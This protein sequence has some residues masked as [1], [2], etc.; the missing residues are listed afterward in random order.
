MIEIYDRSRGEYLDANTSTTQ[1][2]PSLVSV[3][4][5][6]SLDD[7]LEEDE[8]PY[9]LHYLQDGKRYMLDYVNSSKESFRKTCEQRQHADNILKEIEKL[10]DTLKEKMCL[11]YRPSLKSI[12]DEPVCQVQNKETLVS[13]TIQMKNTLSLVRPTNAAQLAVMQMLLSS[14]HLVLKT[15]GLRNS[16][17]DDRAGNPSHSENPENPK[18][19]ENPDNMPDD[20]MEEEIFDNLRSIMRPS[21]LLANKMS[22]VI[23]DRD[24]MKIADVAQI[25]LDNR[26]DTDDKID[27]DAILPTQFTLTVNQMINDVNAGF[28]NIDSKVIK[29]GAKPIDIKEPTIED[30]IPYYKD[31]NVATPD[32]IREDEIHKKFPSAVEISPISKNRPLSIRKFNRKVTEPIQPM[33]SIKIPYKK[34]D[35]RLDARKWKRWL[36]K[37][38]QI[39][40]REKAMIMDVNKVNDEGR[41][42]TPVMPF[43]ERNFKERNAISEPCYTPSLL[44]QP[45]A[46]PCSGISE[47]YWNDDGIEVLWPPKITIRPRQCHNHYMRSKYETINLGGNKMWNAALSYCPL[48]QNCYGNKN[49]NN[50][51][52][53]SIG[54]NAFHKGCNHRDMYYCLHLSNISIHNGQMGCCH[55]VNSCPMWNDGCCGRSQSYYWTN[56]NL[57]FTHPWSCW[58][59]SRCNY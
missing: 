1:L 45:N 5:D 28:I 56:G 8:Y 58:H 51:L 40:N 21:I 18:N 31:K 44:H 29:N 24:R 48:L 39:S 38:K 27:K 33:V 35:R 19:P 34:D 22:N 13:S 36:K 17:K 42:Y 41:L 30:D 2:K 11:T 49:N 4:C 52:Y 26:I 57:Y 20:D 47:T 16:W 46:I 55:R 6:V 59:F 23:M 3:D 15:S 10:Q 9:P 43:R 25:M 37:K 53:S 7:L 32:E 14:I 50:N 54:Y 12:P